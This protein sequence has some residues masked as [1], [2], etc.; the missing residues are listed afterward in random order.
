MAAGEILPPMF[1]ERRL[2]SLFA[3]SVASSGTPENN[4]SVVKR[5][6]S[7]GVICPAT[8]RC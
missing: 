1:F 8:S 5:D 4:T 7:A 3:P 2:V 6:A